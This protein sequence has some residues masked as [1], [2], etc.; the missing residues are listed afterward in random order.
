MINVSERAASEIIRFVEANA[1]PDDSVHVFVQGTCGC[2]AAHYGMGLSAERS[3]GDSLLE[4]SGIRFVID[5][6]SAPYLEGV[7]IDYTDEAMGG[8]F[9]IRNPNQE[10]GSCECGSCA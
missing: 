1:D 6:E 5:A 3:D 10:T 9:A 8:S 7:E 4:V 2:G